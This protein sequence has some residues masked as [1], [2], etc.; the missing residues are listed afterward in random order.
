MEFDHKHI[1]GSVNITPAMMESELPADKRK[2]VVFYC[3]G[4]KCVASK[5]AAEKAVG[6]GYKN[7]YAFREGLS[8]WEKAGYPLESTNRIPD[9]KVKKVST[10]ELSRLLD[11]EDVILLDIN[12]KEDANKFHINH[13]KRKHIPLNDLNVSLPQLPKDKK[14]VVMCLKGTRSE[15]AARYLIGQGYMHVFVVEGGLQQWILDGRPVQ[16]EVA[17]N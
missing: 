11:T 15:T 2:T 3:L 9:V 6:L 14:I 10:D 16:Q 12:L 5:R 4:V 7:V 17:S 1:K 13:S 8:G